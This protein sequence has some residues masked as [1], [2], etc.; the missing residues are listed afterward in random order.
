VQHKKDDDALVKGWGEGGSTFQLPVRGVQKDDGGGTK[1][2]TLQLFGSATQCEAARALIMDAI[3]NKEQKQKQRHK[4]YDKKKEVKARPGRPRCACTAP[5]R[6]YFF[7]GGRLAPG[8]CHCDSAAARKLPLMA[9][10]H[11]P[12]P[13]L[14]QAKRQQRQV[15]HLR[16][17]KDYEALELPMGASKADAKKAFRRL[18]LKWHPDKNPDNREEAEA[19]FQEISRA[20]ESL[21]STD[22]DQRIEQLG[23]P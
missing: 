5:V 11:Y 15:Y 21:M 8:C 4:E 20:Y 1:L 14:T 7:L 22:E 16:H 9:A 17:A 13:L 3:D 2:T 23:F 6:F 12:P 18:A 10:M 19:R